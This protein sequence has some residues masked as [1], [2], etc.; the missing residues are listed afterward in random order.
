MQ[1]IRSYM[2]RLVL[3]I[4]FSVLIPVSSHAVPYAVT[5]FPSSARITEVVRISPQATGSGIFKAV[6]ILPSQA[7][8]DSLTAY[9]DTDGNTRIMDQSWRQVHRQDG[10]QLAELEKNLV[11]KKRERTA[12]VSQIQ[13]L[14]ARLRFWQSQDKAKLQNV[15]EAVALATQ[16][17][18]SVQQDMQEKLT[19]EPQMEELD[20][21]IR[22][23][24]EEISR[25]AGKK[26]MPWEVEISLIGSPV[27][28]T[29]L[30][31]SYTL[32]GC[33][34]LPQYRLDARPREGRILFDWEAEIWQSSGIDWKHVEV[35][36]ATLQPH[37]AIVPPDVPPWIIRPRTQFRMGKGLQKDVASFP[38]S[39]HAEAKDD[40]EPRDV[41]QTTYA[42]WKL[43]K[44]NI[45]AGTRQRFQIRQQV[46]KADF[47]HLLR[48]SLTSQSFVRA[49]VKLPEGSEVP[50][51]TATFMIDGGVLGKRP[52]AFSGQEGNFYFGADPLVT[53]DSVL[54][55][56]K[57]GEK[58]VITENQI[59][60]WSWRMNI[61]NDG[62]SA[63]R[64]RL[65]EPIPQLRDERIRVSLQMQPEAS[66]RS[67]S[68]M[69]WRMDIAAGQKRSI[70]NKIQLTAPKDMDLDLGWRY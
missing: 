7:L 18:K 26:E 60:E 42:V 14:D 48:P 63:I 8:Q 25:I 23:I 57:S 12:V 33:G 70:L 67:H 41:R 5:L 24:Q 29:E 1:T 21:A 47:E 68:E 55:S 66:E 17:G 32:N 51:G 54:L 20:K 64:V 44:K 62:A 3:M 46:W 22:E 34:W 56:L 40:F 28:D 10:G 31:L 61:S 49:T 38:M 19:L 27:R 53:V 9:L 37:S 35:A 58:G 6:V 16:I 39:A 45:P 69:I 50:S 59:Q 52:F 11:Q 36:L 13:S 2:R 4:L 30:T 15:D 65:E 43:G